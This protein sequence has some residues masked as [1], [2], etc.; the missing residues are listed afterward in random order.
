MQENILTKHI[1]NI[2]KYKVTSIILYPHNTIRFGK[3][4]NEIKCQTVF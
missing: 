4:I 2:A 3:S 1:I